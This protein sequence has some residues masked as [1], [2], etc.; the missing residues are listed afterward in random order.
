MLLKGRVR[1]HRAVKSVD[2]MLMNFRSTRKTMHWKSREGR[3]LR[4]SR[5]EGPRGDAWWAE[6]MKAE[7]GEEY[8]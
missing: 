7:S 2:K 3:K 6:V 4:T 5:A 8:R 1:Y